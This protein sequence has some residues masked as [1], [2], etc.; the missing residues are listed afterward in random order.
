MT[1]TIERLKSRLAAGSMRPWVT[2]PTRDAEVC[3]NSERD[4][5]YLGN[6]ERA[7]DADLI[8]DAVNSLPALLRVAEAARVLTELWDEPL[9]P[10]LQ[11]RHAYGDAELELRRAL[12]TLEKSE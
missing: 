10:G 11:R 9:A 4:G 7:L 1:D 5:E 12:D 8:V 2:H 6:A 3:I